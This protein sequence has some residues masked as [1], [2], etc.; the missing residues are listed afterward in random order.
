MTL[1]LIGAINWGTVAIRLATDTLPKLNDTA[2]AA[3]PEDATFALYEQVPTP[4][5]LN[6]LGANAHVQAFI[7]W[8]VFGS[9]LFYLGLFIWNSIEMRTED[10]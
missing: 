8:V 2:I 5:L 3:L 1:L 4:D 6:L 7:Y 10:A 9:G